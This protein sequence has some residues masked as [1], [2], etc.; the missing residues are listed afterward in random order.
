MFVWFWRSKQLKRLWLISQ[1]QKMIQSIIIF[2]FFSSNTNSDDRCTSES[3][4][5]KK[6][7]AKR[8]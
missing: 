8:D 6:T 5:L 4:R 7:N 2:L 1:L 3:K